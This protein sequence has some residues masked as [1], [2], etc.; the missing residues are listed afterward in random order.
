MVS[1]F[2]GGLERQ[3]EENLADGHK[4]SHLVAVGSSAGETEALTRLVS[5]SPEGFSSPVVVARHPAA[6]ESRLR[7][8][9]ARRGSLPVGAGADH[10][11]LEAGQDSR[12]PR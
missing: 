5:A 4:N 6:R 9:L 1:I 12:V 8:M 3:E 10:D 7:G 11:S 2:G